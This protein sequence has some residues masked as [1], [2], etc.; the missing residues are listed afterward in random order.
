[1]FGN[2]HR[3]CQRADQQ[4][5]GCWL[6]KHNIGGAT[7]DGRKAGEFCSPSL[8]PSPDVFVQGPLGVLQSFG[9]ID[10]RHAYAV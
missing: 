2:Q 7:A 5:S 4:T 10:Y 9:K 8:A 1:L 6:I 3:S